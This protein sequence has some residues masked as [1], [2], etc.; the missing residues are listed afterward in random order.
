MQKNGFRTL[1]NLD[2]QEK[3]FLSRVDIEGGGPITRTVTKIV[4][5]KAPDYS[6]PRK[7]RK[8]YLVYYSNWYGKVWQGRR[9]QPV[10]DN[11]EGMYYDQET[12]S[13]IERNQRVGY[14]RSGQHPSIIFHFL[15]RRH[16]SNHI[17]CKSLPNI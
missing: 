7:E 3:A 8:E 12:E 17:A 5:L 14:K 11:L 6:I 2:I 10:T 1:D 9:I 16:L 15:K 4:R 13:I